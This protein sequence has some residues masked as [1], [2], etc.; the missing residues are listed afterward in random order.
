MNL[1][2]KNFTKKIL[3]TIYLL[4]KNPKYI[5]KFFYNKQKDYKYNE[6]LITSLGYKK[7]KIIKTLSSCGINY[8]DENI[9]WHYHIFSMFSEKKNIKNILEI[10]TYNGEFTLFLSNIF[11]NSKIYSI[12]LPKNNKRFINSYN[13][14]NREDM[15]NFLEIR[16]KN[17]NTKNI[18]FREISSKYILN[19]FKKKFDLI[20]I[21]G[22]HLNPQVSQDI[23]SSLSLIKNNG[24]IVCDDIIMNNYKDK[25]VSNDSYK[26]LK[27]LEKNRIKNFFFIKRCR[28]NNAMKKKY[29]SVS[30]KLN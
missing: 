28:N 8:Y 16:K 10:G 2:L 24:F 18:I 23:M 3:L 13:R 21:D 29:I 30:Y 14:D 5:K 12:D 17:I 6:N 22:D 27:A 26:K 4:I 7:N 11:K 15:N 9:S 1:N 20:W 25:Y 19:I